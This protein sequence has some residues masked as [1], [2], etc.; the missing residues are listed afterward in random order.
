M[1]PKRKAAVETEDVNYAAMTVD[2]LRAELTKK[3]LDSTGK[4][5]DLVARLTDPSSATGKKAKQ[6]AAAPAA[7]P[8]PAKP[9]LAKKA[10]KAKGKFAAVA[11]SEIPTVCHLHFSRR[12]CASRTRGPEGDNIQGHG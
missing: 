11:S 6:D 3:G 2:Q 10:S 8:A 7:E 9:A 5:A 1:P 12:C 4:K